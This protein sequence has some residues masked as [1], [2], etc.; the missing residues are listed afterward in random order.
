MHLPK[1]LCARPST[2]G[3]NSQHLEQPE[4]HGPLGSETKI[5]RVSISVAH[6]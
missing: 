4:Q 2:C 6:S 1:L 3:R 5:V